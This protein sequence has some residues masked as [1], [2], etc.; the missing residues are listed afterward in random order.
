MIQAFGALRDGR[1][2]EAVTLGMPD[3]LQ[4]EILTYGGILRRLTLPGPSGKQDLVLSLPDVE[5]YERDNAFLGILVGR[6]A[7]RIAGARFE[8]DGQQHVLAANEGRNHL[9]GGQLGFGKRLWRVLDAQSQPAHRLRLGISSPAGEEGYPGN[10]DATA[11]FTVVAD[12]LTLRFEARCDR[13][14]PLN[15]TWHPYFNLSGDRSRPVDEQTLRMPAS[16]YLPVADSELIPTGELADVAGTPFDFRRERPLRAPEPSSHP[17][18]I[19]GRGYDHC[20]V[21]DAE[22]DC[23][24]ELHSPHSGVT[25]SIHTERRAIQFYGGQGLPAQHPRLNGVC[26]EPQDFPNAPNEPRFPAAILKAGKPYTATFRY[27]FKSGYLAR[28]NIH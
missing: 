26:L 1:A 2:V 11:E 9:H 7:N 27:R 12:E 28:A 25:M 15:L 17:Q 24:A 14:T 20:W 13:S 6:F 16:R 18:L 22:R 3:G 4:A 19:I 5:A 8:L 23:D 10:L 21:L